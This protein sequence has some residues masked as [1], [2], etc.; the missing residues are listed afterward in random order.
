MAYT[1]PGVVV[2]LQLLTVNLA[3]GVNVNI[4]PSPVATVTDGDVLWLTCTYDL[5]GGTLG[6]LQ[7]KN[8]DGGI[9]AAV[10]PTAGT[11]CTVS[12]SGYN[13]D[14][15]N[16]AS[17]EVR[18]GIL[19]PKHRDTYNCS[20]Y[21]SNYTL[22]GQSS[23]HVS[24]IGADVK[25]T[26]SPSSAIEG[27]PLTLTCSVTQNSSIYASFNFINGTVVGFVQLLRGDCVSGTGQDCDKQCSCTTDGK[28]YSWT[29]ANVT[30]DWNNA[31]IRC[32]INNPS[33]QTSNILV[34]DVIIPVTSVEIQPPAGQLLDITETQSTDVICVTSA[35][36]PFASVFWSVGGINFT[37]AGASSVQSVTGDLYI[38]TSTLTLTPS[39]ALSGQTVVCTASNTE[40]Q[41]QSTR[42]PTLNVR[43]RPEILISPTSD[44]YVISEGQK[45]ITLMCTVTSANPN[46]SSLV[47]TKEATELSNN[48]VYNLPV[49]TTGVA[50][51]YTCSAV[52]DDGTT[53][54]NITLKVTT[55]PTTPNIVGFTEV[56]SSTLTVKWTPNDKGDM[57]NAFNISHECKDCAE[58]ESTSVNL[59]DRGNIY[60]SKLTNLFPGSEYYVN[61]TAINMAGSSSPLELIVSTSP[62]DT[63]PSPLEDTSTTSTALLVVG[64]I[65]V[66]IAVAVLG[67]SIFVYRK[68]RLLSKSKNRKGND[69][70]PVK[71]SNVQQSKEGK[72]QEI[73]EER[74]HYQEL[75]PNDIQKPSPY[76]CL[77]EDNNEAGIETVRGNY[78]SIH[79]D[80]TASH[81]YIEI[82]EDVDTRR[83]A[84]T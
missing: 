12:S 81:D 9:V 24:V 19:T 5:G 31:R 82:K 63:C 52:N 33:A 79:G 10:T 68:S 41:I 32:Q 83:Y 35:C 11:P 2:L 14:C 43:H 50:G 73:V 61:I 46:V 18:L 56:T 65:L 55:L 38:T 28:S 74:G 84:N 66:L 77:S 71:F 34:V 6:Q 54:L 16:L 64:I 22:I 45:N 15:D 30:G 60:S 21:L 13:I 36:R 44:P 69:Q 78:E 72:Q 48:G 42:Q 1:L 59:A 39:R 25:L 47:W 7:W 76:S 29:V 40:T 37:Y 27:T 20:V 80:S 4:T 26:A 3:K 70:K 51:V 8:Y 57:A 67:I 23:R 62:A 17:S 58:A 53:S 75:D 49:P